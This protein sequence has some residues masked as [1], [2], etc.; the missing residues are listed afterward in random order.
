NFKAQTIYDK[1]NTLWG[2][3]RDVKVINSEF[4]NGRMIGYDI[5]ETQGYTGN[6]RLINTDIQSS[7]DITGFNPRDCFIDYKQ[8]PTVSTSGDFF[9]KNWRPKHL[10][11][12]WSTGQDH[13]FMRETAGSTGLGGW[14][15]YTL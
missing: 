3:C 5:S 2:D 15:D 13:R 10:R 4:E 7:V 12:R 9:I 11:I 8:F 6:L 14:T 1:G